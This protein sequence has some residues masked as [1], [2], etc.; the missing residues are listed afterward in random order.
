MASSDSATQLSQSTFLGITWFLFSLC[1]VALAARIY[2]RW[3]CFRHLLAEDWLMIA[4]LFLITS[5]E[6]VATRF[7]YEIYHLMAWVN[8]NSVVPFGSLLAFLADTESMLKACGSSIILFIVG[9]YSIKVNFLLFFYRLGNRVGRAFWIAWWIVL[10]VV[11]A[12]GIASVTMG[13]PTF[14][15][16]F[17]SIEYTL[18]TC[19]TH[20]YE[21][22][23]FT[24]FR[25]SVA[26]DIFTDAL[27]EC[28]PPHVF[29]DQHS[30]SGNEIETDYHTLLCTA[31]I[32]FPVWILWGVRISLRKKI[33]LGA[34]FSLV[35]FT[36]VA[37]V[38]R[39]ALLSE[40]FTATTA[41][42]TFNIPWVWFWFHIEF[43]TAFIVACLVSFRSLFVHREQSSGA[44]R[45]AAAVQRR[46][47]NY[48][49]YPGSSGRTPQGSGNASRGNLGRVRGRMKLFQDSVLDT[50]RTLEGVLDDGTT[51]VEL[52]QRSQ[53][54]PVMEDEPR[55]IEAQHREPSPDEFQVERDEEVETAPVA[56]TAPA[57]TASPTQEVPRRWNTVSTGRLSLDS[58]YLQET[59][60][61]SPLSTDSPQEQRRSI[62]GSTP[63]P[64]MLNPTY[65][66][67]RRDSLDE[68]DQGR[69]NRR[70]V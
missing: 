14:K 54:G 41:G 45:R 66:G 68:V 70:D 23:F 8:D 2:I 59:R 9:F 48:N 37:T 43:C 21:N 40:V 27:S 67:W 65:Q 39:G 7:S 15:C 64:L 24:Y 50:C 62:M 33:A 49:P 28:I 35:G 20:G 30:T 56:A 4:T 17:G 34:I 69:N 58:L 22:T 13:V 6:S 53:L 52:S 51:L 38:L 10:F 32:A 3:T 19:Q 36:I 61:V 16:L 31:V 47:S 57:S 55:D 46:P 26:L 63:S 12:C 42:K 11:L 44:A 5:I 25:V 18:T 1:A 60:S 29:S